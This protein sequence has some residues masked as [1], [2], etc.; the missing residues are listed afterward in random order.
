LID[1]LA[2]VELWSSNVKQLDLVKMLI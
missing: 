2:G 1:C